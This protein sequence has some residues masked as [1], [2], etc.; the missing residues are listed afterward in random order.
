[1]RAG[2]IALS[3]AALF[4]APCFAQTADTQVPPVAQEAT[5]AAAETPAVAAPGS[6][7]IPAGTVVQVEFVEAISSNGSRQGDMFAI[8]LVEPI[9]LGDRVAVP[10][11]AM[12]AGEII[13]AE[14]ARGGGQ[15]GTLVASGR[16]L[17]ING[18][19]VRLRG[20]QVLRAG[21]NRT[22]SA[23]GMSMIPVYGFVGPWIRRGGDIEVP[24]GTRTT[25]TLA[26]DVDVPNP[27]EGE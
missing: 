27:N 12:G 22:A 15:E 16:Y 6:I 10:A 1:M 24:V 17:E 19:R 8:R 25:A 7:R 13:D 2:W 3:A 14:G 26:V 9:T 5:M 11:G 23:I 21:G 4:S 20:M 18:E